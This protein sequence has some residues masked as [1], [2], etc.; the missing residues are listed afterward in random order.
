ML[1]NLTSELEVKDATV[2]RE[3]ASGNHHESLAFHKS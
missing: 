2:S 3:M 1:I